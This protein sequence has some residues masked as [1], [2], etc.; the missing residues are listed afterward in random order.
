MRAL[1]VILAVAVNTL[2]GAAL[3]QTTT[4]K[5]RY[6]DSGAVNSRYLGDDELHDVLQFSG[7]KLSSRMVRSAAAY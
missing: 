4:P 7:G 5:C 2:G 6:S 3:A 1:A